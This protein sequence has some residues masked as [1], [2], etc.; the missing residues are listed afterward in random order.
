MKLILKGKYPFF[1]SLDLDFPISIFGKGKVCIYSEEDFPVLLINSPNIWINNLTLRQKECENV[2]AVNVE[3]G[4]VFL[5]NCT[6]QSNYF[7]ISVNSQSE[8]DVLQCSLSHSYGGIK[9]KPNGYM[10]VEKSLISKNQEGILVEED[11]FLRVFNTF[12]CLS[13]NF[14]IL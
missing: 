10:N 11:G 4:Y 5:E 14:F 1:A 12:V 6:I 3:S 13:F 8:C 9:I 7:C 2:S